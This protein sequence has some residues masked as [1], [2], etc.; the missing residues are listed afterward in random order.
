MGNLSCRYYC[1][2]T[3]SGR[4]AKKDFLD[5]YELLKQYAGK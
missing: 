2:E 1:N 5:I 3:R 4:R